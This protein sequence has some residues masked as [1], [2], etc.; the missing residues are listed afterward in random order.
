[1]HKISANSATK[2]GERQRVKETARDS[3]RG[4]FVNGLKTHP[5]A[6]LIGPPLRQ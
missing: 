2:R 3:E 5:G 4:T 1:M 6:A